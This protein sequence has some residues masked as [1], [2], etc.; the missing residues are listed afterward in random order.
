MTEAERIWVA[1]TPESAY[2]AHYMQPRTT[3]VY[4]SATADHFKLIGWDVV[5]PYVLTVKGRENLERS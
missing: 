3:V 4:D 1:Y 5:G 2:R